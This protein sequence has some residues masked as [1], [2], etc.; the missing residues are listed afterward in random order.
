MA[1]IDYARVREIVSMA[2]VLRLAGYEPAETIG[3]QLRG[4]CPIHGSTS[5]DSRSLSINL[6]KQAFQCFKCGVTGNQLDLWMAIAK[7]P[8][9][10][11]A[12]DL[13]ERLGYELPEIRRW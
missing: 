10:A 7:L 1:G 5:S 8:V 2:D 11:A 6:R 13:C 12:K 3:D 9:Y 4:P